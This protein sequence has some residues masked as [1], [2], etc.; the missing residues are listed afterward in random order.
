[1]VTS[2]TRPHHR[3]AT[4][5][6]PGAGGPSDVDDVGLVVGGTSEVGAVT[7]TVEVVVDGG[8]VTT[9]RDVGVVVGAE[10]PDAEPQ[11]ARPVMQIPAIAIVRIFI[12]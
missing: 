3:V 4:V 5:D 1:V 11:A 9:G 2:A 10:L 7:A 12:G 8:P 6:W